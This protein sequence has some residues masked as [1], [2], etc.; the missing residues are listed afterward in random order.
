MCT[1]NITARDSQSQVVLQVLDEDLQSPGY[2]SKGADWLE[3]TSEYGQW[4]SGRTVLSR[5]G[6]QE[7]Y[8]DSQQVFLNFRSD[9]TIEG[10]GFWLKYKGELNDIHI[11]S[12][13]L[14]C[15]SL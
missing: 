6:Q 11:K 15:Y 2:Q 3:Y 4:G 12:S 5:D 9:A 8:T 7:L 10:R 13:L 14:Y 1:C